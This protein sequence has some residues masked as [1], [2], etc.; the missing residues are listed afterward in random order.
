MCGP[1]HPGTAPHC[2]P[3][4]AQSTVG[5]SLG[6]CPLS[7]LAKVKAR[8]VIALVVVGAAIAGYVLCFFRNAALPPTHGS[9]Q[10]AVPPEPIPPVSHDPSIPQH[11]RLSVLSNSVAQ[12]AAAVP[13][14]QIGAAFAAFNG[15][16]MT[17]PAWLAFLESLNDQQLLELM[18]RICDVDSVVA[19]RIIEA[20]FVPLMRQR[21]GASP[22]YEILLALGKDR[23]ARVLFREVVADIVCMSSLTSSLENR[24]LIAATL[25]D[26][27]MSAGEDVQLR[28]VLLR[29]L[30]SVVAAGVSDPAKYKDIFIALA[31]DAHQTADV[32]AASIIGA[33]RLNDVRVVPIL[34]QVCRDYTLESDPALAKAAA[35][36]LAKFSGSGQA[37]AAAVDVVRAMMTV[38]TNSI[39]IGAS[40]YACSLFQGDSFAGSLP[41]LIAAKNRTTDEETQTAIYSALSKHPDSALA[42]LNSDDP[43]IVRAGVEACTVISV[44]PARDRLN[45]LLAERPELAGLLRQALEKASDEA[46]YMKLVQRNI[47]AS[48]K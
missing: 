39:V 12:L 22:P 13:S 35:V 30:S 17:R 18:K 42:A 6:E 27:A 16:K 7:M 38:A 32:R 21:W 3:F 43:A 4:S 23:E 46:A 31:S 33:E 36:N 25:S 19:L 10:F 41:A 20:D 44:F 14:P 15:G 29:K 47:K 2:M 5:Q 1:Q 24:D 40:V 37:S 26:L 11:H 48:T 34:E 8:T 45:D 9:T 28:S